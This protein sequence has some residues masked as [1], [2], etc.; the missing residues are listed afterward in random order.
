[1]RTLDIIVPCYNE[2]PVLENFYSTMTTVLNNL[3]D[4]ESSLI[5]VDDGSKD[6]TLKIIKD[7]AEKDARVKYISFS[8]NF[9]KEGAMLAGLTYSTADYV[10]IIDADLQHDPHLIPEM[11]DTVD[12]DEYDVAAAKRSDRNGEGKLKSALSTMF[13][14]VSN[15]VSDIDI[16]DGAQDF[17]IMKRK[18]VDAIVALSEKERFTKGIFSFVGFKTKWFP[19]ENKERIAGE[20]KWSITKLFRYAMNGLLGY[21]NAPLKISLFLGL[22][23]IVFGIVYGVL[24]HFR[25]IPGHAIIRLILSIVSFFSGLIMTCIGIAGEYLARIYTE[26]KNRPVYIISETNIKE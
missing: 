25:I 19:H 11:L 12:G 2:E 18:V 21:T 4:T 13:Y 9:G 5:F 23:F 26:V 6:N 17:R 1:M 20:S 10:G 7:Y 14:K 3:K 22:F 8:R 24:V 15:S 16:D